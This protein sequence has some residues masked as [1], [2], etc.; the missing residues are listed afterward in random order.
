MSW[1]GYEGRP[2][3]PSPDFGDSWRETQKL[4]LVYRRWILSLLVLILVGVT[5]Y[6]SYFTVAVNEEAIVLR[7]GQFSDIKGPGLHFKLPFGIDTIVK[8]EVNTVHKAEFGFRTTRSDVKSEF[9]YTD[10]QARDVALMLTADLNVADIRWVVR[11]KIKDLNAYVFNVENV[12]QA[13]R[14]ASE[15]V[16]RKIVGDSSIDEVLMSRPAEMESLA[17]DEIQELLDMYGCGIDVRSVKFKQLDPPQQVKDAFDEVNQARQMRDQIINE[18]EAQKNRE[19]IP[20]EGAKKRVIERANG[21]REKRINEAQ[22]NAQAFLLVLEQ[23]EKAK[24]VTRRRL[25]LETM[26]KVLPQCGKITLI[27]ESQKGVL[28]L[29]RLQEEKGGAR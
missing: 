2:R 6:T 5:L 22:G 20:A 16:M 7:F 17:R 15:A 21:Y 3:R 26:A 13:I 27:D 8:E 11:Y 4:W 14:D 12:V 19:L 24:E 18:A 10:T 1:E 9:D 28:P 29:L 23:Y 25:Y